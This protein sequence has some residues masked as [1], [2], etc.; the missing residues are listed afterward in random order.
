MVSD[1]AAPSSLR[2]ATTATGSVAASTEPKARQKDHS[3]S[4][5]SAKWASVAERPAPMS[6]PGPARSRHC[7][8]H[9]SARCHL[10]FTASEKTSSGKKVKRRRWPSM[11]T[12]GSRDSPRSPVEPISGDVAKPT[13]K[14]TGVYGTAGAKRESTCRMRAPVRSAKHR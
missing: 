9:F 14:S 5:G 8:R 6:T 2:S 7:P 13:I 1:G 10:M 11:Y 3:Q 4:Y 12:H